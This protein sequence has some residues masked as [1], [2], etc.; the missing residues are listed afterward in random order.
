MCAIAEALG[1]GKA[2]A[3]LTLDLSENKVGAKG[4]EAIAKALLT[5]QFPPGFSI[6]FFRNRIHV[7]GA[8]DV[9]LHPENLRSLDLAIDELISTNSLPGGLK[10]LWH[11]LRDSRKID[12]YEELQRST[13]HS[14]LS[15]NRHTK[16]RF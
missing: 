3:Q 7:N 12:T 14:V 1:S 9:F 16:F 6:Q 8:R 10:F 15:Y 5:N 13:I 4:V 2:P 11:L